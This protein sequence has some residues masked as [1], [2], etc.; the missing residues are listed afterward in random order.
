MARLYESG[1]RLST[2]QESGVHNLK[3]RAVQSLILHFMLGVVVQG[4]RGE[5]TEAKHFIPLLGPQSEAGPVSSLVIPPSC[6]LT[7]AAFADPRN[8][9]GYLESIHLK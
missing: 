3:E 6:L 2:S 7:A 4:T 5:K 9:R 1:L 8:S